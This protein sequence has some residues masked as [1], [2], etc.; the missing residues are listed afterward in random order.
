MSNSKKIVG[1]LLF[2]A[3][4]GIVGCRKAPIQTPHSDIYVKEDKKA[5]IPTAIKKG[6]V[7][8]G[9]TIRSVAPGV[10][11]GDLLV[12]GKH[13]VTVTIKYTDT[14]Y[15]I[16]YKDS[17]NMKSRDGMIHNRYN[18]WVANLNRAIQKELAGLE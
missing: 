13:S 4:L 15:T 1:V 12:R 16:E 10:M 11:E 6:G 14:D 3:V 18:T 5:E 17:S 8:Q 7:S 2:A 9:W